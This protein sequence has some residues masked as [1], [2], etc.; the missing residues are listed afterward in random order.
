MTIELSRPFASNS[1]VEEF[2][3]RQMKKTLN[4]LGYYTPF[5]K[6]GITGISDRE[7]FEALKEFQKDNNLPASGTAKP[8]DETIDALNREAEKTPDGYYIWRTVEDGHV[9][10]AHARFNRTVRRWSESPDPGDDY[11]C[12]C[13]AEKTPKDSDV[14]TALIQTSD[15]LVQFRDNKK[16]PISA[17]LLERYLSNTGRKIILRIE[18]FSN[19][20]Q[21]KSALDSNKARFEKSFIQPNEKA[22][23]PNIYNL[24]IKMGNGERHHFSDYWDKDINIRSS[25]I[26]HKQDDPD[27]FNAI[28]S[29]KIRSQGSFQIEK[30]NDI[31]YIQGTILNYFDDI[32]DFND[33]TIADRLIFRYQHFLAKKHYAKPFEVH[34]EK[35][36]SISGIIRVNDGKITG[37]DFKWDDNNP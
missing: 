23:D 33:D 5:E 24:I 17:L 31:I 3:L 30:K 27:F 2:D 35:S 4:R 18:T 13:W 22:A 11:N 12:R 26:L 28:G 1:A 20:I 29:I 7:I 10:P 37:S 15:N 8:D 19:S 14:L 36:Q 6:T 25:T 32:Y 9:R 34:W 16:T 21:L